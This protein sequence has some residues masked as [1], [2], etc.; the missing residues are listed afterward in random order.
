MGG[1]LHLLV[2]VTIYSI[3]NGTPKHLSDH[4]TVESRHLGSPE[5]LVVLLA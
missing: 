4:R 2:L 1:K 5:A 3:W